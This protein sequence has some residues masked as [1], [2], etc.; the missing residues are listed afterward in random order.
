MELF[1]PNVTLVPLLISAGWVLVITVVGLLTYGYVL[2][3]VAFAGGGRVRPE[4]FGRLDT[5]TAL[6]LGLFFAALSLQGFRNPGGGA[7]AGSS[8]LSELP[9]PLV[10]VSTVLLT[11]VVFLG[12]VGA[13]VFALHCG[14][15]R[16][17]VS[18]GLGSVRPL[19]DA[20][21][22][23]GLVTLAFPL[24]F[25][26]LLVWRALLASK[27]YTDDSTQD[28]VKLLAES[29]S[30][31]TRWVVSVQAVLLAPAQEEIIFRGYIY[32]VA[33]R[34]L[35][36]VPALLISSLLF[37]GIHVHLPSF[38]GLFV[39][40]C[41]LALAYEWTGSLLVPIAMHALFNLS[42]VAQLLAR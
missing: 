2:D 27:G 17:W 12:L 37:A 11:E 8:S 35:G 10:I 41:C 21:R 32:G 39:L 26:T 13:I 34:H 31:V 19:P 4:W 6:V 38:A 9:G 29:K 5:A 24:V 22:A 16:W 42:T 14:K 40:A 36:V 20:G 33:R 18:L 1:S 23:V 3:R 7:D 30:S 28:V 15:Q 25:V